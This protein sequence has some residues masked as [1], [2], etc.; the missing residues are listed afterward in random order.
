M[1][2]VIL[3]VLLVVHSAIATPTPQF[4]GQ[5]AFPPSIQLTPLSTVLQNLFSPIRQFTNILW[6]PFQQQSQQPEQQQSVQ[7]VVQ[8]IVRPIIQPV[9]QQPFVQPAQG[10]LPSQYMGSSQVVQLPPTA[11]GVNHNQPWY[12][13]MVPDWVSAIPLQNGWAQQPNTQEPTIIIVSR[14]RPKPQKPQHTTQ[15]QA[16][17][18]IPQQNGTV[19][20]TTVSNIAEPST[21]TPVPATTTTASTSTPIAT[22]E[23]QPSTDSPAPGMLNAWNRSKFVEKLI[24]F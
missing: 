19:S 24:I 4:Q 1:K 17:A 12:F 22:E 9:V 21:T 23:A 3:S 8:Q 2:L 20:N 16:T 7:P 14:P 5:I 18:E 11:Y 15:L 13:N 10:N 6:S